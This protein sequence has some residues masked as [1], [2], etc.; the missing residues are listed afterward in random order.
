ML[1]SKLGDMAPRI[2]QFRRTDEL[3]LSCAIFSKI[4]NS[5]TRSEDYG[6]QIDNNFQRVEIDPD[7]H[8]LVKALELDDQLLLNMFSQ[9]KHVIDDPIRIHAIWKIVQRQ[10]HGVGGSANEKKAYDYNQAVDELA[11]QDIS[12]K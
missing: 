3:V 11:T 5:E 4:I 2:L 12:L 7:S 10:T 1:R 8:R 6:N 9:I